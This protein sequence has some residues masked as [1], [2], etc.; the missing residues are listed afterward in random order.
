MALTGRT[1]ATGRV[2]M[3]PLRKTA[4]VAGVLYLVTFIAGIPPRLVL[5]NPLLDDADYV[6]GSG[7][8]TRVLFGGLL[9]IVNVFACIG[10]AVVLYP[11]LKRQNQAVALGF[12]TARLLEGAVIVVGV[13]SLL[14]IV[15]LRQDVAGAPGADA[16]SLVTVAAS[17][18]AVY[19]WT[20]LL[21]PGLIPGVNALL[22]G[23]LLYRS[24]LVPRVIPLMGLVGAPIFLVSAVAS[25]LGFNEQVSV[26]SGLALPLIF[27]WELSLG[28]WLTFKGF[29]P[30]P[31]TAPGIAAGH[32]DLEG[33]VR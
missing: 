4:T 32:R 28:L 24:G 22:L 15:S 1:A 30:S 9:D 23:Y 8:D 10:T 2:P 26:W 27:V 12:V 20:W 16:D 17:H 19:D 21:G 11:V 29:K 31:I 14:A 33:A 5:L 6:L 3:D 13:V 25:I 18:E 7:A